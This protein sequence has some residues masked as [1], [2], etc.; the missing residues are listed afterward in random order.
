MVAIMG[1][2]RTAGRIYD[3]GMDS[4]YDLHILGQPNPSPTNF[5]CQSLLARFLVIDA[6]PEDNEIERSKESQANLSFDIEKK[7]S[8]SVSPRLA[9]PSRGKLLPR[10]H[11]DMQ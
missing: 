2:S 3:E 9:E 4:K 1:L 6:N 7:I 11:G 8:I 10:S 5:R